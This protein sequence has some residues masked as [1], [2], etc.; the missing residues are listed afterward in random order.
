MTYTIEDFAHDHNITS[1]ESAAVEAHMLEKIRLSA[2]A[3]DEFKDALER[4]R[5]EAMQD[6]LARKPGWR[7]ES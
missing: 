6:L 7:R 3:F 2:K 5:P 4:P 1:E